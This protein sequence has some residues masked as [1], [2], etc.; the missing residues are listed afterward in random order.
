MNQNVAHPRTDAALIA[1][2]RILRATEQYERDL[3][4][5]VRL[6]PAK[7]RVL[8]ILAGAPGRS[9]TPTRLA[10]QMG[11]SQAT[12]TALVD[13]LDKLAYTRRERSSADRRQLNVI[14]TDAGAEALSSAPDALQQNF[15]RGF[16]SMEDWEQSMLV[17]SLERVAAMLNAQGL[18]ASP[19]LTLGE[20][21]RPRG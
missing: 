10:G 6:T 19:V 7:L 4:Q 8:Q 16:H 13:Q 2:R 9:A 18:D 11:V 17:A 5:S 14:L 21:G 15:V 3:A 12:V 1:L 20:I